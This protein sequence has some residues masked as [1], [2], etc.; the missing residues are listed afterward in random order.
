MMK[1]RI[2]GGMHIP[3]KDRDQ[4]VCSECKQKR[5]R[6]MEGVYTF[7]LKLVGLLHEEL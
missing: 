6:E 5:V 7:F 2:V 4:V 3:A 1:Q